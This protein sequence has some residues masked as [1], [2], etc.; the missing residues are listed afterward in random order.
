MR[1]LIMVGLLASLSGCGKAPA[2]LAHGQPVTHWVQALRG[3]EAKTRKKAVKVLANVGLTDAAVLPALIEAVKDRDA[4]VRNEAV[5]A[6][7]KLGP[8]A[9]AAIP[10]LAE[11]RQDKDPMVRANAATALAKIREGP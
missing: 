3:S 8:Q 5:L 2:T 7:L 11:A 4:G 1:F 10:A 6:L 9:R